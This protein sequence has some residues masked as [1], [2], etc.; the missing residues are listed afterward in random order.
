MNLYRVEVR[1]NHCINSNI[2]LGGCP[3]GKVETDRELKY[4]IF[5]TKQAV[6][7]RDNFLNYYEW[8]WSKIQMRH[9]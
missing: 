2:E 4:S 3:M 6:K 8:K 9:L 7:C 1:N 5:L